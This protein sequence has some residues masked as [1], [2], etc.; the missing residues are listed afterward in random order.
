M[1]YTEYSV[2]RRY[3]ESQNKE[4]EKAIIDIYEI[5]KPKDMTGESLLIK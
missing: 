5:S 1:A 2:Y 3:I 4:Y